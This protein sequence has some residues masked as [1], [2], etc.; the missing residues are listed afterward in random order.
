MLEGGEVQE[1]RNGDLREPFPVFL[2]VLVSS[3]V[4]WCRFRAPHFVDT[5]QGMRRA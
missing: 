5:P 4:G 2:H 3:A 1:G